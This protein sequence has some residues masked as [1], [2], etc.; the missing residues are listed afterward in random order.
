MTR[1]GTS[2]LNSGSPCSPADLASP[3]SSSSAAMIQLLQQ[4]QQHTP[5]HH[6]LSPP[7]SN[8]RV[9]GFGGVGA[10]IVVHSL[11]AHTLPPSVP[12]SSGIPSV[13]PVSVSFHKN[14]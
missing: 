5:Q 10:G 6:I 12:S 1:A 11:P 8:E 9:D 2:S 13:G 3:P 14:I 4:Q 7:A